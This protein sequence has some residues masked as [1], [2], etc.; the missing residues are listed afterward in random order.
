MILRV[1]ERVV[2]A[3]VS[4]RVVV[5]TDAAEVQDAC[6]RAGADVVMTSP[7]HASGTDRVA[8]VAELAAYRRFD[9]ILN[10]QG[11]EPFLPEEAMR[12][13]ASLVEGGRFPMATAAAPDDLSI[14]DDPNVVKVVADDAGRALYFTRAGIPYLRDAADGEARAR[15][16][17]R[18]LGVYAYARETLRRLVS[19]PPHPLEIAERLE[20]LR[21][22]AAGI[23]IGVAVV[24]RPKGGGI[25]TEDELARANARWTELQ[26]R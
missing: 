15:L 21:A 16:V 9:T 13:P 7:A 12:G 10:V 8:E 23:V 19:L 1:W 24:P 14:L 11:D 2:S 18:H 17:R 22:L 26:P 20:Q 25:D 5:A 6:A 3:R 4:E